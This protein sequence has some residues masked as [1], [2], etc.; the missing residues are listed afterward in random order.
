MKKILIHIN[1]DD[2]GEYDIFH[3]TQYDVLYNNVCVKRNGDCPNFGN[4]LWFQGIIS[5]IQSEENEINYHDASMTKEYINENYDL[6]IAPMANIFS[7]NYSYLLET[8]TEK[9]TDIKI[10]VYVIACGIQAQNYSDLK[11]LCKTLREPATKFIHTIYKTGGEFALR[12]YFTKE[13]FDTLG[14]SSAVVTGCPSLY[15]MGRNIKILKEKRKIKLKPV[16]NGNLVDYKNILDKY[17]NA[18]FFAQH[19]F[20]HELYNKKIAEQGCSYLVLKEMVKK[21]GLEEL[22]WLCKNKIR[23]IPDM[24]TWRTYLIQQ[25]FNFSLGKRIHGTIMPILAGIPSVLDICDSRTREMAEFFNIPFLLPGEYNKFHSLEDIY[26]WMDY[27]KFN[28]SFKEKYN[29]FESFL[30]KCGIVKNINENNIFFH[31]CADSSMH[32]V[33]DLYWEKM[34]ELLEKNKIKIALYDKLVTMK[35]HL[36]NK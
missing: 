16:I 9:F 7:I 11:T 27:S 15:Q 33:N 4:R 28:K 36:V 30:A 20:Y 35:R 2:C 17:E 21:Y 32:T 18:E 14:F 3:P 10:P 24:N 6:I 26:E 22:K 29:A 34:C 8:L 31:D 19:E 13:F 23:L 12:G 5:E 1:I 25:K